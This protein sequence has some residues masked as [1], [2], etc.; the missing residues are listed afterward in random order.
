[1]F[2]EEEL[3]EIIKKNKVKLYKVAKSIL[4]NEEDVNDAIQETLINAYNK[5]SRPILFRPS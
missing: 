2:L 4:N 5:I 1:M 3:L